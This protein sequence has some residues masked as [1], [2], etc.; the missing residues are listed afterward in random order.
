MPLQGN[1]VLIDSADVKVPAYV[2][3]PRTVASAGKLSGVI[4]IHDWRGLG[5]FTKVVTDRYSSLG[6]IAIAPDL[7]LGSAATSP[8]EARKLSSKVTAQV[9]KKLLESTIIYLKALDVGKIGITGFCFGGTHAFNQVCESR[10]ISAGVIYYATKLP[11]EDQLRNISSP[12]LIIYGDQDQI[13]SVNQ[14]RQLEQALKVL[15]KDAT[16]LVYPGCAHAFFNE[17]NKENY[18]PEA[19]KDAWEKTVQFFNARLLSDW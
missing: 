4:V 18:R 17:E 10:D 1:M 19:A 9:S 3:K 15:G 13:V 7:Y 16:L 8:D 12:L 2:S 14:A 6:Y 5:D 11:E